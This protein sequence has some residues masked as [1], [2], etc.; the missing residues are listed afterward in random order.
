MFYI[1]NLLIFSKIFK[2]QSDQNI[3]KTHQTA[4][5]YQ[6]FAGKLAYAPEPSSIC[7]QL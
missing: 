3:T 6:N 5:Y 7:V 2:T 1:P 4:P